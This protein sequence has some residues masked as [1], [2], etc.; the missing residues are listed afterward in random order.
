VWAGLAGVGAFLLLVSWYYNR[1]VRLRLTVKSSWSD[2]DVHL[3]KRHDLVPNLVQT[4]Q[5]YA[6]HERETFTKVTQLR[7][8]AMGAATPATKARAENML[9]ETIRSMFALAE[10]YPALKADLHFQEMMKQLREIEDNIEYARRYYNA[11]VRD[12][13]TAGQV[14]PS[15]VVAGAF[16]FK[17][18]EFFELGNPEETR[19]PV[20]VSFATR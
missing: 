3:R 11:N 12:Y 9:T 17:Q 14:F 1:L 10:A 15:N 8:T 19:K 7:A 18:V 13:N 2:I 6:A 4:V 5:G 16:G 20:S